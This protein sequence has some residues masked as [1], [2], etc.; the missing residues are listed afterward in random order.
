M[1]TS[2]QQLKARFDYI[3]MDPLHNK[4]STELLEKKTG[5]LLNRVMRTLVAYLT[6]VSDLELEKI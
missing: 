5:K 4:E 3:Y 2:M 1:V 6:Q